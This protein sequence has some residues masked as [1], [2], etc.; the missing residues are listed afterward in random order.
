MKN[1]RDCLL[2]KEVSK[3]EALFLMTDGVT[4]FALS[5]DACRLK[6]G[7]IEPINRYLKS[8]QNKM[9]ALRALNNTLDTRQA[10]R[11]HSDDKTFLWAG[12]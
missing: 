4:N 2:F 1:W 7:F 9:P 12:R 11:L 8:E 5:D 3:A 6:N 10:R